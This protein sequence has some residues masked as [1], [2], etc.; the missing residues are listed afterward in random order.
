MKDIIRILTNS[1][2]VLILGRIQI[3]IA[4]ILLGWIA[5]LG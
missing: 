1:T 2:L 5:V 3:I 4:V